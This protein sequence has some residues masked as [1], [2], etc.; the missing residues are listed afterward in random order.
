MNDQE[1]KSLWQQQQ[2][3]PPPALPDADLVARM[4]KKMR[5]F[6]RQIFWRDVRELA[7][8]VFVIYSY[9]RMSLHCKT[10]LGC[11][12][13]WF[14]IAGAVFI[15]GVI[16]YSRRHKQ[17]LNATPSMREYV[18]MESRKIGAQIRLLET[19]LWWYILPIF[20]G[21]EM[22]VLGETPD[23]ADKIVMTVTFIVIGAVLWW[24]NR[25]AVKKSLRPLQVELKKTLDGAPEF[26]ESDSTK[27]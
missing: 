14:V 19:V 18:V 11:A 20:I 15:S 4:K 25:Y 26:S 9:F 10:T 3:T 2:L 22:Y 24:V 23:L 6:D 27:K 13:C 12:G 21:A 1:L 5:Q 17:P 7:A 8:A 16:L